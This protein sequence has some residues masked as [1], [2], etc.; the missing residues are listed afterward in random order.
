MQ[1]SHK[2]IGCTIVVLFILEKRNER[3][4]KQV[5][6]QVEFERVVGRGLGQ[7]EQVENEIEALG[8]AEIVAGEHVAELLVAEIR[9]LA[10]IANLDKKSI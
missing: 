7:L 4:A 9:L 3:E 8:S 6:E 1:Q 5:D 10:Q 2:K